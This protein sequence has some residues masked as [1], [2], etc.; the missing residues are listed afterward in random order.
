MAPA[1]D[2]YDRAMSDAPSSRDQQPTGCARAWPPRPRCR[3]RPRAGH[4]RHQGR[5]PARDGRRAARP[6][7]RSCSRPTPTTCARAEEGGTPAGIVDRL[8]LTHDRL[9]AMAQGLRDVA[10][11]PDPVGEVVRGSTLANGLEMRQVR[12]PF[13]V[14]GDDLR[15]P[16]QRHRRRRRH[17]PEVR[18][19]GAAARLLERRGQQ[20]RDRRGAARRGRRRPASTPTWCRWCRPTPATPSRALM[21]AR[22]RVDVLIP[23]G[24]AGL[25]RSVVEELDGAGHRDRRRQLP[26][27][28]R[29]RRRP[30]QGP[31]GRAQRQDPPPQRLQR[32]RDAARARRPRRDLPAP[33]RAGP[34]G[35]RGQRARRRDHRRA[36]RASCRPPTTTGTPS[37]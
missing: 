26:R 29:P 13:G 1:A 19:R 31:R 18:Q 9:E 34:A 28:R 8:R 15:G 22:G 21:R 12:V 24:G 14:V 27:L 25:I 2:V 37:T 17:L 16:A 35:G 23:R 20:R 3:P 36:R 5:R 10:G 30:R 32:R 4:P 6:G 11:L 7:R 33:G